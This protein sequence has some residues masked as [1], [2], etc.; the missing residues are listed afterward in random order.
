MARWNTCNVVSPGT[1]AWRLWQFASSR[2]AAQLQREESRLPTDPLPGKLV[3]KGW[4]NFWQPRVN[5]AWLPPDKV[6]LRALQLPESDP[7]EM[8]S[9]IELQLEKLSPLPLAQIVWSFTLLPQ[10]ADGLGTAIVI[11]AARNFVEEFLG[12]LEGKGFL[13]D[14]LEVPF[15]DQ[16][17]AT[18]VTDDGVW[19]HPWGTAEKSSCLVVWWY[20][21]VLRNLS[22]VHLPAAETRGQILREQIAQMSWAGE[23]EGWLTSP[24]RWHLVADKES[25]AQWEAV[26]NPNLDQSFE[27]VEP[28][29]EPALAALTAQRAAP[30]DPRINLVPPEFLAH[31]RQEF[32]DRIWMRGLGA[33]LVLY[34]AG[35]GIYFGALT[36]R[37]I[38]FG[39]IDKKAKALEVEY[40]KAQQL[41]ERVD[42]MQNQ[43]NLQFAALETWKAAAELLPDELT[44]DSLSFEKGKQLR[45]FGKAPLDATTNIT[46]YNKLLTETAVKGQPI[47][48]KVAAPTLNQ[49]QGEWSWSFV[50]DLKQGEK[51]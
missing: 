45:L 8:S 25:A 14:R 34:L 32:V 22:L 15:L 20:G 17:L 42:V 2:D 19:I 50:C 39:K 23:L 43:L 28:V 16:L 49:R 41:S 48:S 36:V 51:E 13:A 31:Y 37:N 7:A 12:Q 29:S 6:F 5:L 46:Y 47:F 4:S 11:I 1:D 26:I 40:K 9:M 44:L 18:R 38:Q 21:G 10:K 24:P 30:A 35:V 33:L 3:N 27:T